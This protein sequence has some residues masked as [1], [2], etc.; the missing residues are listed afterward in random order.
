MKY[1]LVIWDFNGTVLD[2]TGVS[3]AAINEVMKKRNMRQLMSKSELQ[4]I[5][6]FP[7]KEYY[8]ALGFDFSKEPFEIP[9]DEWVSLYGKEKFNSPLSDGIE[10][11]LDAL[12]RAGVRQIILSA[13]EKQLLIDQLSFHG[14]LKYFDEVIGAGDFYA[15]G[16]TEL[17]N[18]WIEENV[19]IDRK[20]ILFVGDTDHDCK[21]AEAIG[22]DCVLYSG[23]F[24]SRERLEPL[25]V[26]VIDSVSDITDIVLS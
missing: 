3:I 26:P 13:S 8:R 19:G 20:K 23:G 10:S 21:C 2:D 7:A 1:R 12:H 9:A 6:C 16:K 17:A 15:A 11:T 5:F 24:M 25:G 22:C 4:N 18:R 14:I